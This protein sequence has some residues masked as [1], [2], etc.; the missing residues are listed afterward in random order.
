MKVYKIFANCTNTTTSEP[1]TR[2]GKVPSGASAHRLNVLEPI[3]KESSNVHGGIIIGMPKFQ[4]RFVVKV[5][6]M[7]TNGDENKLRL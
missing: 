6:L 2:S 1:T 7:T 5:K 4:N 3:C